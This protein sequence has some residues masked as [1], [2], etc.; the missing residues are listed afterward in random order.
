VVVVGGRSGREYSV[1][2]IARGM[3]G[4]GDDALFVGLLV[5]ACFSRPSLLAPAT[6]TTTTTTRVSRRV[7]R[8]GMR[9]A[10]RG[11]ASKTTQ[12]QRR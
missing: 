12:Q 8:Q 6:T 3:H 2:R 1:R 9:K 7:G 5:F 4:V 10:K 11:R